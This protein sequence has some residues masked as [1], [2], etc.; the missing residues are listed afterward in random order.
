MRKR[1]VPASALK[2][3]VITS[4]KAEEI[5]KPIRKELKKIK[6]EIKQVIAEPK[7]K[8]QELSN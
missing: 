4:A 5:H 7:R 2:R 6:S 3:K 8:N 1:R